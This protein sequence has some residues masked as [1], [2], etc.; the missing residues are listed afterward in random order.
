MPIKIVLITLLF[1][2]FTLSGCATVQVHLGHEG[3]LSPYGGTRLALYKTQ[4]A[5]SDYDFYGQV[6]LYAFDVPLS[7]VGD[8]VTLPYDLWHSMHSSQ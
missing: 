7:L 3:K 8:T 6:C 5:W 1:A 2:N 4:K